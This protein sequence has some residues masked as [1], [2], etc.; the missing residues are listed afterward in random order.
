VS[1]LIIII[2]IAAIVIIAAIIL[3]IIKNYRKVGPNEVL[4]I[5]GGKKR[6]VTL[7]DGTSREVGYRFRIGGGTLV[8]PFIEQAQILP[9]EIIPMNIQVEDAIST[10][11]IRCTVRGTAEVKI[12]G[13]ETSIHLAAEQ[14]LGKPLTDIRDVALRTLEGSSRALIGS[15]NLE[16]LNKNRKDFAKKVFEDV[17]AYFNNM[18]LNLLSFNLKEITDPSGYLEA[19]GKPR[20]VEARRDAEVAEAEAARDAII[21]SAEAKK[22]GDIARLEAETK[23][24]EANQGMEKRKAELQIDL[25]AKKADA[26]FAYELE[27][28][29]LN[30]TLKAEEAKVKLIEKDSTIQLEK[31]EI[32][33]V[34][35]ELEAT[36]RKP[37]EAEQFRLEAEAK[38]MAEAKRIQ[39]TIEADLIEKVGKAE[40]DALR[41]KAESWNSYSDPAVLQMMF[42]K[43]PDLAREMAAPISKV[44]KIVMV[45]NDGKMGTSKITGEVASM[46]TQLPTV[47]KSLSGF[48][49]EDWI[50]KFGDKNKAGETKPS[51]KSDS[52]KE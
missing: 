5:S 30:Q 48:D 15:M 3:L 1:P 12:S 19:L 2:I 23:V 28:H 35:Q 34:E 16:S 51:S 49:L 41:R 43:L 25:N 14:F 33:R 8:K 22:E 37:A 40:A 17:G 50:K 21:K 6:S 42:E 46:L 44:E 13:D 38:G 39:G 20:I 9:L 29:K 32:E 18:G 10:N 52:G 36:V 4:I 27:R 45:S 24:A 7:P 11:G 47:V 31:K 26:D